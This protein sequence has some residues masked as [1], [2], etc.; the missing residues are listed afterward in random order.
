MLTDRQIQAAIKAVQ[1]EITLNDGAAGRGTG[2]LK[3]VVRRTASGV[4]ATWFAS[5]KAD[6]Q[7]A[8]KSLGRYPDLTLQM[9]RQLFQA[10]VSPVIQAGKNPRA[11]VTRLD[12]PTV[13]A[14]FTAYVASLRQKGTRTASEIERVLLTG[15]D[16][17]ADALGR[18]RMA[19]DIEP[20]DV[21]QFLAKAFNRG[22]RRQADIQRTCMA[23]A[24]N[25]AIKAMH[26]YRTE[27]RG[28]W[29]IK[30]NPAAMVPRDTGANKTR[31]RNLSAAELKALWAGLESDRFSLEVSAAA[32]LIIC[33]G[34]RVRETLRADGCDF[35]LVVGTWNM[36]AEKTKGGKA[37]SI[38]LPPQ[39]L[40][41][42]RQLVSVHGAGPLFP[43]RTGAKTAHIMDTS[44]HQALRRWSTAAGV[45]DFQT[46]DLR[47]TWKSRTADA[48]IDR[49][50]RDVIQQHAQG[51]T[52][53][54]NYDRA[55]YLPQMRE[56]MAKWAAWLDANVMQESDTKL[57]A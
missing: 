6:G 24:F 2:S 40:E 5:W 30:V 7:R 27:Q 15:R 33:C 20:G 11:T 57:A 48:G 16:N 44:V 28:D 23:A 26:D 29:G 14:L 19:G 12:Q 51:G 13:G 55:D 21:S 22:S 1:T 38:P 45:P 31:D 39:A 17:A 37:H 46:K 10:E 25:W 50:T 18:N 32:R 54:K 56:A 53:T 42:V 49:F 8:K 3:L 43:A 47:R 4:S 36:P 35:D 41:V 34:Q 52:G 9:A